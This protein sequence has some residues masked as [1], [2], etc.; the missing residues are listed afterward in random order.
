MFI[1]RRERFSHYTSTPIETY[2]NDT[3]M[4]QGGFPISL[5]RYRILFSSF[6]FVLPN[7]QRHRRHASF[8][9]SFGPRPTVNCAIDLTSPLPFV[10]AMRNRFLAFISETIERS[11]VKR[12]S[13]SLLLHHQFEEKFLLS[14]NWSYVAGD[15][16]NW[17][18]PVILGGRL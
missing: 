17:V 1:G 18:T 11:F 3:Y 15:V 14:T 13:M 10:C 12:A 4:I 6:F 5:L 9:G 7:Y 2:D 8:D 16:Y